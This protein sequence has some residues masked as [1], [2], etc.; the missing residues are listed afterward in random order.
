MIS[1]E[2]AETSKRGEILSNSEVML[3]NGDATDAGDTPVAVEV[4]AVRLWKEP[5]LQRRSGA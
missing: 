4:L 3:A 1:M 2:S 5:C